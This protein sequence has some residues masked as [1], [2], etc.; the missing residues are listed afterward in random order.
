MFFL[1]IF[2]PPLPENNKL[3]TNKK[4]VSFIVLMYMTFPREMS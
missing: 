3:N 2:Y 1:S 4:T